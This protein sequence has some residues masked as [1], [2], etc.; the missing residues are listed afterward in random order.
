[1][2]RLGD[3]G[4]AAIELG[5]NKRE[6]R[7]RDEAVE[8]PNKR[9]K[10][11]L[12]RIVG[13]EKWGEELPE[14]QKVSETLRK[15]F[16]YGGDEESKDGVRGTAKKQLVLAPLRGVV[17]WLAR[18]VLLDLADEAVDTG[19]WKQI[20]RDLETRLAADGMTH[21]V[22]D[23]EEWTWQEHEVEQLDHELHLKMEWLSLGGGEE[24]TGSAKRQH[25][26]RKQPTIRA[27]FS[28]MLKQD[29]M[30]PMD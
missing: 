24:T 16:L 28:P 26:A 7:H 8:R 6:K 13:E 19:M 27:F 17:E 5:S 1:M 12:K 10:R 11:Q 23:W 29:K 21:D 15:E 4:E 20:G 9:R 3:Q 22:G 25:T 30:E 14:E 18:L 2:R